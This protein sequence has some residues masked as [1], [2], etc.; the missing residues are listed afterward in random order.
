MTVKIQRPM[1]LL[2]ALPLLFAGCAVNPVTGKNEIAFVSET[3]ELAIGAKNYGPYRQ[4]QGGDYA[5][6]PELT[7]YVQSVG[8]RLAR[9][10][11]R[12]LPYEFQVL[13]ESSPNAWALPGGKI[14]IN[15]GLLVELQS[16]AELAAVLAHEIVHAAARHSAQSMERGVFLQ[17]ALVAA[18][19]A[20]KTAMQLLGHR[21]RSTFDRYHIVAPHDLEDALGKAARNL[22][23]HAQDTLVW[24][25]EFDSGDAPDPAVWS[26]D[27]G[28][29]GWG[30]RELMPGAFGQGRN[31]AVKFVPG[32]IEDHALDA[33]V[34][35]HS[36][37]HPRGRCQPHLGHVAAHEFHLLVG[38]REPG[39]LL[40]VRP[41]LR[42]NR[43]RSMLFGP[44]EA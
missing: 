5:V 1:W 2:I 6:E 17:G 9:V 40:H 37:P 36:H 42:Q 34:L 22:T 13:N 44:G 43:W 21:S 20:E 10:S 28:A 31:P 27:L 41:H 29:S 26:Y 33:L 4:A 15:R 14:A 8:D 18:G 19:V 3:Q 11:D 35:R 32:A 24:S 23:L 7:R 16:E 25:E 38:D 30:N 12:K 39:R